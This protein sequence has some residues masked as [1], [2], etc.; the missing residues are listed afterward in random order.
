MALQLLFPAHARPWSLFDSHHWGVQR[1]DPL[2]SWWP[3][4]PRLMSGMLADMR[5]AADPVAMRQTK[6]GALEL[7]APPHA[8]VEVDARRH[9]VTVAGQHTTTTT[10]EY[11]RTCTESS[12]FH[13]VLPLP[14]GVSAADVA[15]EH[16]SDGHLVVRV[17]PAPPALADAAPAPSP[18]PDAK[19]AAVADGE[20]A[21]EVVE[22][23]A[24]EPESTV[25]AP[26]VV[27][28]PIQ[29]L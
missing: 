16:N 17:P 3:A 25:A 29:W 15:V 21:A 1:A 7:T 24:H 22:T 11:G 9:A 27:D 23:V 14:A 28:V 12:A 26:R 18:A 8:R 2:A 19:D 13:R 5:P 6:D 10:D 20:D 4:M